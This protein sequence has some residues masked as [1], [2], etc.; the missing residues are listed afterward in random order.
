M[1]TSL[2]RTILDNNPEL[3]TTWTSLTPMGRLGAPEDLKGAIVFLAS[4][5]SAFVTGTELKVDGGYCA[6]WF[7]IIYCGSWKGACG[8]FRRGVKDQFRRACDAWKHNNI[9]SFFF[10]WER[11]GEHVLLCNNTLVAIYTLPSIHFLSLLI[12]HL[13]KF[14]SFRCLPARLLFRIPVCDFGDNLI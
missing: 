5:S 1:V 4:D 12:L 9:S 8:V 13:G 11:Q 10:W 6:T 7:N 14:C 2:T 3:E